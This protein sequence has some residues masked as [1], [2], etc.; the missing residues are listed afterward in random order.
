V[1]LEVM[2]PVLFFF[3]IIIQCLFRFHRNN[4]FVGVRPTNIGILLR[5]YAFLDFYSLIIQDG[6]L[7]EA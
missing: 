4:A 5:N 1:K 7:Q 6:E 3:L 2:L